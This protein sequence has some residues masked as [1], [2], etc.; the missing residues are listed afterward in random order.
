MIFKDLKNKFIL[1]TVQFG[2]AY[3][4]TNIKKKKFPLKK[5]I[6]FLNIVKKISFGI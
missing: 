6:K 1:G 3:G 4:I 2:N 5:K